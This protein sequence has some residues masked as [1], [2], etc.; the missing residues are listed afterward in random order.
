MIYPTVQEI[1]AHQE[2]HGCC[3]QEARRV[4]LKERM[5]AALECAT[6]LDDLKPIL[7]KLIE[8]WVG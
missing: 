6:T 3:I 8:G 5:Q 4:L 1:K 2:K 7:E